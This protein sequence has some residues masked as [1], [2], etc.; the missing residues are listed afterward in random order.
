M[1]KELQ[2][3]ESQFV[4]YTSP[5]GEVKVDVVFQDETIWLSQKKMAA[6]FNVEVNT[7]NYHL[8]EIFNSGELK[9]SSTIQKI[10]IVQQEGKREVSREVEFYNLDAIIAIGYRVNSYEATQ[11]R[12][13]ATK[14]LKEF[15][16]KGFVMDDDRL[17]NG[18][19]FGK[20]YFDE[21]LERIR[22]IR[23]SERR[24]YQKITDI[25]AQCSSDYDSKAPVSKA[26]YATVQ[27]KL[28][29]AITGQTASEIVKDRVD[30]TKPNA[31]L[32][33]WKNA[34][35]GKVLKMDV[36]IAK[37][38]L[39]EDELK[40]LNRIVTMYLD[41]AE[42]QASRQLPITMLDWVKKL[43]AF[44]EFNNYSVLQHAGKV[45]ATIAKKLA[46][47]EYEKFRVGQDEGFE[48]DFDQWI[49]PLIDSDNP[50]IK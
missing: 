5:K 50:K 12:I 23:A 1:S 46:E 30:A 34:P 14:T 21:L 41:Y 8:K 43:D 48:S 37:N 36:L 35:K 27:N 32:K 4:M 39:T 10:R 3:I 11:F 29:W 38:F 15:M 24:F 13:W 17:K 33:T 20:D 49:K 7:I 9:E 18:T 31:G 28:H 16:I 42:N 44:L 40:Q 25:Y 19:H 22:E 6:L 2:P 47:A 26:F 45:Q